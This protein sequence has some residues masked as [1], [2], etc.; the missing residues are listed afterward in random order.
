MKRR[1]MVVDGPLAF[2]M[3]RVDAA[4]AGDIGL[5]IL[6]IPLLAGRLAGGFCRL[7]DREVLA[8]AIAAA[9]ESGGFKD[10]SEVRSL[11]G[12]VRA[13]IQT[14]NRIWASDLDLDTLARTSSRLWDLALIQ[15]PHSS[16]FA[17]R[18]DAA[19]RRTRRR[20][21]AHRVCACSSRQRNTGAAY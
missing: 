21:R 19:A 2:R 6:T 9:L 4:R 20:A 10:V 5:E 15:E 14:L 13:V 16:E 12:M 8:P 18:G 3:R 11:P 1:V 7:A 17:R